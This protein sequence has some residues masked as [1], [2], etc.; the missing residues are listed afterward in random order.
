MKT[1]PTNQRELGLKLPTPPSSSLPRFA[2][3]KNPCSI[4]VASVAKNPTLNP[5]TLNPQ[6]STSLRPKDI[7]FTCPVVKIP[8][9]NGDILVRAGSIKEIPSEIST[10][11]FAKQV[12]C[13]PRTALRMIEEGIIKGARKV[14][15]KKGSP[16][17]I[18]VT[19]IERIKQLQKQDLL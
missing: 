11:E 16:H 6:P 13:D 9:P 17:K 2:P 19:E 4:R 18:P 10:T 1:T 7:H 8:Q 15:P 14:S 3:S 5:S 12:G